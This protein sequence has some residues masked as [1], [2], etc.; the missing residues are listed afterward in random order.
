M[1]F[2]S[3][4]SKPPNQGM[5]S[6]CLSLNARAGARPRGFRGYP[7][8]GAL[9][10]GRQEVLGGIGGPKEHEKMVRLLTPEGGLAALARWEEVLKRW[11]LFRT[12][13]PISRCR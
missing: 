8:A 6:R 7:H 2:A 3:T 9:R 1:R 10:L 12:F 11:R 5:K 4:I 13:A